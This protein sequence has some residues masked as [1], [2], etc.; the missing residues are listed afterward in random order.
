[1]I[2]SFGTISL[3]ANSTPASVDSGLGPATTASVSDRVNITAI[4]ESTTPRHTSGSRLRHNN[5]GHR[6]TSNT[7]SQ[8]LSPSY[9]FSSSSPPPSSAS[10]STPSST[11]SSRSSYSSASTSSSSK[12]PSLPA[13][14]SSSPP[15]QQDPCV[16]NMRFG[17][18]GPVR[19][20]QATVDRC[21][22]TSSP[23][24]SRPVAYKRPLAVE[25]LTSGGETEQISSGLE[26]FDKMGF[27]SDQPEAHLA[28]LS[29]FLE[30][31]MFASFLDARLTLQKL[32]QTSRQ[33]TIFV[34]PYLQTG[35]SSSTLSLSTMIG[36][37]LF[38]QR[39]IL[40]AQSPPKYMHSQQQHNYRHQPSWTQSQP[41]LRSRSRHKVLTPQCRRAYQEPSFPMIMAESGTVASAGRIA[42]HC[43]WWLN[44]M[45][46]GAGRHN[47]PSYLPGSVQN[48][49]LLF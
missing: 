19:S 12:S 45:D 35:L 49:G 23:A 2:A 30:T 40:A 10:R 8:S 27:L 21:S 41:R 48:I 26:A 11:I 14:I 44:E 17:I 29:A 34:T 22:T 18:N 28:F 43:D 1:M 15:H 13:S 31:Q 3:F 38:Y 24:T 7:A 39:L 42:Q 33:S 5:G 37:Q 16:S 9:S 36:A 47:M 46:A 6:R 25:A 32:H 4:S 20:G